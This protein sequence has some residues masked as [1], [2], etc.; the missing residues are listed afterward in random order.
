MTVIILII[1]RV[2]E[3]AVVVVPS[4][5][6]KLQQECPVCRTVVRR[7][8][9]GWVLESAEVHDSG[10]QYLMSLLQQ[11]HYDDDDDDDDDDNAVAAFMRE[12]EE[13]EDDHDTD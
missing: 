8:D 9:E 11:G 6:Q 4:R 1:V 5:R 3:L 13:E 10:M 12:T 7:A 2:R